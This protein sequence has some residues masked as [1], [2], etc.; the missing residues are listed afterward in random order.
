[1]KKFSVALIAL[2]FAGN[3][4]SVALLMQRDNARPL[5][6]GR[7]WTVF[8]GQRSLQNGVP[9]FTLSSRLPIIEDETAPLER[10]RAAAGG[11]GTD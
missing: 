5:V 6:P 3:V 11:R 8:L 2:L 9:G 1:M 4:V 10:P 7:F